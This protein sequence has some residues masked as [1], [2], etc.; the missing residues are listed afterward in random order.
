MYRVFWFRYESG[1]A[2]QL[3]IANSRDFDSYPLAISFLERRFYVISSVYWAG[4]YIEDD[5]GNILYEIS[6]YGE[7][8]LPILGK[9]LL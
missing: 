4:G 5:I 6:P 3:T 1:Y 7:V 8:S 2:F 9:E